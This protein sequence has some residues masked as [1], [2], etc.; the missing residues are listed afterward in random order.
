[1]SC[2]CGI[3]FC[4]DCGAKRDAFTTTCDCNLR[5]NRHRRNQ[6]PDGD[7]M[8][9]RTMRRVLDSPIVPIPRRFRT[10][11]ESNPPSTAARTPQDRPALVVPLIA[12]TTPD[13]RITLQV[14]GPP[15]G[16]RTDPSP[17]VRLSRPRQFLHLNHRHQPARTDTGNENRAGTP[18]SVTTASPSAAI[19]TQV[20][21]TQTPD[22]GTPKKPAERPLRPRIRPQYDNSRPLFPVTQGLTVR[23]TPVSIQPMPPRRLTASSRP[24]E[25]K[26]TASDDIVPHPLTM[27]DKRSHSPDTTSQRRTARPSW[28]T[29]SQMTSLLGTNL[30]RSAAAGISRTPH[31]QNPSAHSQRLPGLD[32]SYTNAQAPSQ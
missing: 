30:A 3:D 7:N 9:R 23:N 6:N 31:Q 5:G 19:S 27:R 29:N 16:T 8:P 20:R 28:M 21:P 10:M 4:Y 32:L 15:D 2:E 26:T 22:S 17:T 14:N 1:M 13:T 25:I 12:P 18:S 24:T 11:G